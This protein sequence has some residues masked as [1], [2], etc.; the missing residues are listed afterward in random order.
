M[1]I[2]DMKFA[3]VFSGTKNG[4]SGGICNVVYYSGNLSK[5]RIGLFYK[6]LKR[7]RFPV[8][9]SPL[10]DFIKKPWNKIK[11]TYHLHPILTILGVMGSIILP[12]AFW[13]KIRKK[14]KSS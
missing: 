6:L 13:Q 3:N 2:P 10:E 11:T 12:I 7:Q 4:L 14:N 1:I 8:F 9:P 5:D